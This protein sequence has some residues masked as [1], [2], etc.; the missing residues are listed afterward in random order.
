MLLLLKISNGVLDVIGATTAPDTAC[1][2][3]TNDS[4]HNDV[5]LRPQSWG[6]N[7]P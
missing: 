4:R 3:Q 5:Q 6:L 7:L 2:Q 1:Q